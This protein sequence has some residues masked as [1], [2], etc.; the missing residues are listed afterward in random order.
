VG[1]TSPVLNL[2]DR[3]NECDSH[4]FSSLWLADLISKALNAWKCKFAKYIPDKRRRVLPL[5]KY[6]TIRIGSLSTPFRRTSNLHTPSWFEDFEAS[7]MCC[8]LMQETFQIHFVVSFST[9]HADSGGKT[10]L[11]RTSVGLW[12]GFIRR[13]PQVRCPRLPVNNLEMW[14]FQ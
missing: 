1:C 5:A 7:Q 10:K 13:I 8:T 9:H 11:L 3:R 4:L 12:I 14:H 2:S 6:T